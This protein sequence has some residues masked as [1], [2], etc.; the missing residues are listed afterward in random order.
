MRRLQ[1]GSSAM[2]RLALD[3]LLNHINHHMRV[4]EPWSCPRFMGDFTTLTQTTLRREP[5]GQ[6]SI[7]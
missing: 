7:R 2:P 3:P 5:F 4:P 1:A 6:K